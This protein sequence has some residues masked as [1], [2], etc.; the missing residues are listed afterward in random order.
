MADREARMKAIME[1]LE[2]NRLHHPGRP[3]DLAE[4]CGLDPRRIRNCLA[5]TNR[6][7]PNEEELAVMEAALGLTPEG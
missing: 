6:A 7:Q 4:A 3:A 5:E 2:H 1:R